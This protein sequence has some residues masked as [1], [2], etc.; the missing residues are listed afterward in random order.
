MSANKKNTIHQIIDSWYYQKMCSNSHFYYNEFLRAIE[1]NKNQEIEETKVYQLLTLMLSAEKTKFKEI[2]SANKKLYRGRIVDINKVDCFSVI[3]DKLHGLNKYE[4]KE[5]PLRK[6]KDGRSNLAGASYLYVADD[7]YTAI[8]ECKPLRG[9]FISVAEFETCKNLKM[10]NLCDD[11]S[12]AELSEF[13]ED[14]FSVTRLVELLM[15]TFYCSVYDAETGYKASQY[16]TELVRKHGYDGIAFKSFISNGK[17]Y[18]I[19]NCC[20]SNIKFVESEIVKIVAQHIDIVSLN[21]SEDITNPNTYKLPPK[22]E[23]QD[24]KRYLVDKI[25]TLTE[26]QTN[27]KA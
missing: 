1:I 9:S 2:I 15:R 3:D 13:E 19:F 18:T 12:T 11:D 6:S 4:S 7:K 27:E 25:K 16:I 24:F 10:F 23:Y 14:D 17:N 22:E 21:N 20:E 8:A 5:P 26:E